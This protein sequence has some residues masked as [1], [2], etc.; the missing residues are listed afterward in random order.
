MPGIFKFV[1]LGTLLMSAA[2]GSHAANAEPAARA[3]SW[4]GSRVQVEAAKRKLDAEGTAS[5][6]TA[7][8]PPARPKRCSDISCLQYSTMLGVGF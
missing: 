6:G 1:V 2:L 3:S 4:T 7:V 5:I 8:Q